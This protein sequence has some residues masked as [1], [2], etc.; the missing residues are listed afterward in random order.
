MWKTS[1]DKQQDKKRK[2]RFSLEP[3][4][5]HTQINCK[6]SERN[7]FEKKMI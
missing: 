6:T 1:K 2:R 7:V 3:E 4:E 5:K